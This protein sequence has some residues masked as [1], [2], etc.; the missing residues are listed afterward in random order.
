MLVNISFPE[1]VEKAIDTRAAMGAIGDMDRFQQFQL[2]NTMTAAAS[3]PGGGAAA[4]GMGLG[5]GL[6]MAG[7]MMQ[8]VGQPTTMTPPP[9]PGGTAFHVAVDGETRGPFPITALADQVTPE[10]LVWSQGMSAWTPAGRVP[11]LVSLFASP[12]PPPPPPPP[13]SAD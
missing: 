10:T 9:A 11:E 7:R 8:G 6:A 5:M 2:G 13:P 4:D 12:P 1:A 3:N